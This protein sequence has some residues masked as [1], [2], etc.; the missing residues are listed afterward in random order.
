MSKTKKPAD[1]PS[2]GSDACECG[3]GTE[4]LK[5]IIESE[6]SIYKAIW[7][8]V[9]Q[10]FSEASEE[11]R[12]KIYGIIAPYIGDVITVSTTECLEEEEDD[13]DRKGKKKKNKK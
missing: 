4:E 1:N 13:D 5:S 2:Q 6:V 11:T 3:C 9:Q 8:E 10:Q 12:I 7:D